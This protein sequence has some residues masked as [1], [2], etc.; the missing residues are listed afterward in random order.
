MRNILGHLL[1]AV[2]PVMIS[3]SEK[4]DFKTNEATSVKFPILFKSTQSYL[5]DKKV[6]ISFQLRAKQSG[7][8]LLFATCIEN[9]SNDTLKL[10]PGE[11]QIETQKNIRSDVAIYDDKKLNIFPKTADTF[12]FVFTPVNN[13]TLHNSIN[14]NGDMDSV[15]YLNL[16]FIYNNNNRISFGEKVKFYL[17]N[18]IY[19]KF[20]KQFAKNERIALYQINNK[21]NLKKKLTAYLEKLNLIRNKIDDSN[22]LQISETD[23]LIGGIVIKINFYHLD[24]A[25]Y[26]KVKIINHGENVLIINPSQLSINDNNKVTSP[27]IL[28]VHNSVQIKTKNGYPIIKG[29]R[30]E[31]ETK[32]AKFDT[33]GFSLTLFGLTYSDIKKEVFPEPIYFVTDTIKPK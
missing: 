16:D 23:M 28:S 5:S 27:Q 10:N 29:G 26:L 2:L 12:Q 32:Y 4:R 30:L 9:N 19:T 14:Y 18:D 17:D 24:S 15:Y 1:I 33:A 21:D 3:C 11:L 13:L 6:N 31:L 22:S 7:D 8:T 25:L 20:C